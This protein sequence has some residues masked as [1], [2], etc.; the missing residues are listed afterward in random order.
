M[1]TINAKTVKILNGKKLS[2]II[3]KYQIDIF[4]FIDNNGE[5]MSNSAYKALKNKK[6]NLEMLKN[7]PNY[8]F[9][10]KVDNF[11]AC[12]IFDY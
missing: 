1:F 9:M 3:E 2:T 5:E 6:V 10:L 4:N 7:D 8:D 12:C 11:I